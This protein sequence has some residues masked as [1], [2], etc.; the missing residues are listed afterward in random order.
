M[1][2]ETKSMGTVNI[3]SKTKIQ[4][5]AG[6]FGFEDKKEYVILESQYNSFLWLQS[7]ND[8][9]LAFL[10]I[11]PFCFFDE[12]EIELDDE[13]VADLGIT[14]PSDV[15]ILTIV[16]IPS[17]GSAVTANLQGPLIINKEN[18]KAKQI[19][20]DSSQWTTKHSLHDAIAKRGEGC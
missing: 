8:K 13:T 19:I 2:I 10:V 17:D 16:T 4:I 18:K 3:D 7:I 12:Y 5:K 15:M 9:N 20:L 1:E 11:D 14:K 6:L